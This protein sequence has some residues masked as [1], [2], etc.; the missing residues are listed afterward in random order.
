MYNLTIYT[1]GACEPN[2]G[3]ASWA[4]VAVKNNQVIDP[5][6]GFLGQATS[7]IGELTAVLQALHYCDLK[8]INNIKIKSD[9]KYVVN[10]IT[11]WIIN[12]KKKGWKTAK[13]KPVKNKELWEEL[14]YITEKLNVD[15]EWVKG[16]NKN[17][18]NEHADSLA[19]QEIEI[20][21]HN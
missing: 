15:Y 11:N 7:N 21:G 13:N 10:G 17:V 4:W 20:N 16:H 2:P 18:Y 14:D 9:S 5:N 3:K 8:G 19:K 6:S 1:D 12:W